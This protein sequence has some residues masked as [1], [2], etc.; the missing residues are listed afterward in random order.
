[1]NFL[2]QIFQIEDDFYLI[3]TNNIQSIESSL[4]GVGLNN[5]LSA[6]KAVFKYSDKPPITYILPNSEEAKTFLK[7]LCPNT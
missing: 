2:N 4:V 3:D 7:S 6:I 5:R 1:M